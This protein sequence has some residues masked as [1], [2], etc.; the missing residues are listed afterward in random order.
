MFAN[1]YTSLCINVYTFIDTC[2]YTFVYIV[3][4]YV[5]IKQLYIYV[6][7]HICCLTCVVILLLW[8][9]TFAYDLRDLPRAPA[10]GM[11]LGN[12]AGSAFW[13]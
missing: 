3:Y 9:C 4:I 8:G 13:T 5:Y 1:T 6:N 12:E 11:P 7:L 10:R 2:I